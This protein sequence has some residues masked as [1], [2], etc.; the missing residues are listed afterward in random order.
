LQ[1]PFVEVVHRQGH[2]GRGE[3]HAVFDDADAAV[4]FGHEKPSVRGDFEG[5]GV[6]AGGEAAFYEAGGQHRSRCPEGAQGKQQE[7]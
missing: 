1:A 6:E 3:H 2:K 7:G 4:L 5:S